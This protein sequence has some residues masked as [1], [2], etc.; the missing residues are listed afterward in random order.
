MRTTDLDEKQATDQMSIIHFGTFWGR[1]KV[2]V[3][4]KHRRGTTK[5]K[6]E[7]WKEIAELNFEALVGVIQTEKKGPEEP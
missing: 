1:S 5:T 6:G 2:W 4:W 3:Q 7:S